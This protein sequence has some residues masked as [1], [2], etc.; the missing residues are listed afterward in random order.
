MT[1]KTDC[2]AAMRQ[3]WEFLDEELS[4]ERMAAIRRHHECCQRCWP[5]NDF[6][7]AFL[8]TVARVGATRGCPESVRRQVLAAL[9]DEG[10]DPTPPGAD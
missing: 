4:A 2:A 1:Q 8:A 3:L 7:R 10:F 6:E 5:H 9:R